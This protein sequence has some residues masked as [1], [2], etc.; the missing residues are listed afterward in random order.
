MRRSW[1]ILCILSIAG[2]GSSTASYSGPIGSTDSPI[3]GKTLQCQAGGPASNMTFGSDGRLSGRLLD[4]N[5]TGTWYVTANGAI[6]THVQA[7]SVS[8]RDN[9]RQTGNRWV[10][11]TTTCTG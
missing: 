2:C 10:G 1:A 5:I 11:K 9:L 4:E 6:H 7:G 8:L 3:A